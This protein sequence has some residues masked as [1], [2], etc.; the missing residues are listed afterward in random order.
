MTSELASHKEELEMLKQEARKAEEIK[1]ARTIATTNQPV[2]ADSISTPAANKKPIDA[3]WLFKLTGIGR[4]AGSMYATI[5]GKDYKIGDRL[6]GMDIV[7]IQR[8][9][10]ICVKKTKDGLAPYVVGFR[11]K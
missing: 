4:S 9:Q 2:S 10:V 6:D 1:L 11:R 7:D 3:T 8:N 5:D